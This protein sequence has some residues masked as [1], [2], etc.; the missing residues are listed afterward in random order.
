MRKLKFITTACLIMLGVTTYAQL[1]T[2][3]SPVSFNLHQIQWRASAVTMPELNLATIN[4]EDSIDNENGLPP[5]FGYPHKVNLNLENAGEWKL[6][7]N[8]DRLWNLTIAC[9]GAKSINLLY[10]KY[11]LPEGA[12]L[13]VY[14]KDKTRTIGAF[15]SRNNKGTRDELRGFATGLVYCDTIVVEYFEPKEIAYKGVVSIAYVVHGYRYIGLKNGLYGYS[16][17]C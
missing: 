11:W 1:S 14:S 10:D 4:K 15:T 13:F 6:L 7:P 8:G 3:E 16:G 9:P 17:S 12:K 5:R 2:D